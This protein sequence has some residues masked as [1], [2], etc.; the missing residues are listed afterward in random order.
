M[1]RYQRVTFYIAIFVCAL[2]P[3][4]KGESAILGATYSNGGTHLVNGDTTVP[5]S[6]TSITTSE[7][8]YTN[9]SYGT[10]TTIA[11]YTNITIV[12]PTSTSPTDS[13]ADQK[14][15]LGG[16]IVNDGLLN[17]RTGTKLTFSEEFTADKVLFIADLQT[18]TQVG[19]ENLGIYL[20]D[21]SGAQITGSA[22]AVGGGSYGSALLPSTV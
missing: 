5:L 15:A 6:F 4:V 22:P 10:A 20:L 11:N 12:F 3:Q 8:T 13:L 17:T 16:S 14:A 9:L 21:D 19:G 7:G 1:K 2:L 18:S